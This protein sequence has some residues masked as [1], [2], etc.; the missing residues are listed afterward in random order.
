VT[1]FA[2]GL[3][4]QKG[5][6]S[7][8]HDYLAASPQCDPGFRKEYHV[9]DGLDLAS[10]AWMRNR[11]VARAAKAVEA[12]GRGGRANADA[13]RQA[14]FYADTET[15]FDYF[16]SLL[17]RDGI[18]LTCDIT[19]S[20][21]LLP[22]ARLAAIREGFAR[23]GVRTAPVFLMRDPVERVWS[24]VRMNQQR[25]PEEFPGPTDEWVRRLHARDD[26]ALR[27]R[28]DLTLTALDAAY[29]REDVWLG[30][31]ERLFDRDELAHLCAH[32]GIDAHEPALDRVVNAS[33]KPAPELPDDVVAEVARHFAPVYDAV[34]DRFP[35]L[36]LEKL[37]PT[38]RH[39]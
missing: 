22:A 32:L 28:Y 8:L 23:R 21:A 1:T 29:P 13:L 27:T 35:T 20:Y 24:M 38:V 11:V 39:L 16:A 25:R 4:C 31:Y 9:F 2:L 34:A 18:A 33:P 10:E 5:G 14:A 37:W 12:L 30:F 6:T 19:P 26:H 3:G 15:Y 17:A 7:W 36:D